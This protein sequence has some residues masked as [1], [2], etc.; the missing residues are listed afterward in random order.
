MKVHP[1]IA[2][3]PIFD[4]ATFYIDTP[5]I[6]ELHSVITQWLWNGHSGGYILGHARVGKSRAIR[7]AMAR[8]S[9]RS[10]ETIPGFYMDFH[11]RDH[12]TIASVFRNLKRALNLKL[13]IRETADAMSDDILHC[14]AD[15]ALGNPQ[16]YVVLVV[17]EM[18]RAT[19][20]QLLA[21]SELYDVLIALQI[22]LFVVFI[23][24]IG[25]SEVLL[26]QI[27]QPRN[28]HLR[29]RFFINSYSYGG[30]RNRQDAE[31]CLR[32]YDEQ[33][34]PPEG[35]TATQAF[36]PELYS[37]GWRLQQLANPIWRV[38]REEFAQPLALK[39]WGMQFFTA[40]IKTLLVDYLPAYGVEHAREVED[41]IRQSIRVSGLQHSCVTVAN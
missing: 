40:A 22:N 30:L 37:K 10:G 1:D 39:S 34:F 35:P 28:E 13:R 9:A 2:T 4:P 18:Q 29:G 11:Q 31:Y 38:Y 33:H 12:A 19:I 36:L 8:L 5:M 3:H 15:A 41:M 26:E 17:D 7:A 23:A 16:H 20:Q 27:T 32:E 25:E 24:N 6:H 14:L 21:F